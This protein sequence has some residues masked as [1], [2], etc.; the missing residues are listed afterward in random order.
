MTTTDHEDLS[1]LFPTITHVQDDTGVSPTKSGHGYPL[2]TSVDV[3][4]VVAVG[5]VVTFACQ[6][7]DPRGRKLGWWLHPYGYD[8]TAR[9]V[10]SHVD[11]EWTVGAESV[12]ECVYL[13]IGM[14]ADAEYHREGGVGGKGWDGWVRY[15]F[16]VTP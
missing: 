4:R 5:D 11:L 15:Q 10:G 3:G 12:G 2:G 1:T 6:G 13:G 9:T 14:A 7:T 16:T 8:A